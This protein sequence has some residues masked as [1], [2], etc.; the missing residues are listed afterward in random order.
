MIM[1]V[2]NV[3]I[4]IQ[5]AANSV[6]AEEGYGTVAGVFG[7]AYIAVVVWSSLTQKKNTPKEETG[8]PVEMAEGKI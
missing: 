2:I 4:G 5:Y 7:V 6:Q 8:S 3:G 1:A